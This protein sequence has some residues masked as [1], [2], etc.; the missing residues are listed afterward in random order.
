MEV[1]VDESQQEE[2]PQPEEEERF[3]EV[4]PLGEELVACP[5]SA[6]QRGQARHIYHHMSE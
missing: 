3:E 5:H 2:E 4:R 1:L 6:K